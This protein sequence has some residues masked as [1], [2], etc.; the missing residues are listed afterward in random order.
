MKRHVAAWA[1][2]IAAIAAVG[3]AAAMTVWPNATTGPGFLEGLTAAAA[4]DRIPVQLPQAIINTDGKGCNLPALDVSDMSKFNYKARWHASEWANAGSTIAWKYDHVQPSGGQIFLRL[5]ADG[6]PQL[7]A[8]DGT[9][10]Q[11]DGLW[12]ADVTLP[13]LREGVIVAPLWIYDRD[14]KDEVDFEFAGR[15]GLDVSMHAWPG[16]QHRT[17][18]IRLFAGTDFSHKRM[19]F[20]IRAK[21]AAGQVE[22]LINGAVVYTWDRSRMDFY[23]S[24]PMRPFIEM[25]SVDP[26]SP[27]MVTWAGRFQGFSAGEHMTMIVNGYRFTPAS[28]AGPAAR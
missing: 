2:S 12:E 28:S 23:I 9:A 7:Q 17:T 25:W 14:T 1:L 4:G 6:A 10:A 13:E 20:G 22:M 26:A 16:G 5:D 19:C 15:R 3:G 8:V 27:G 18:T 24:H 21:R 11:D